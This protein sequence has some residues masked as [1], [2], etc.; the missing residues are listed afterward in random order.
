MQIINVLFDN[1]R[2]IF[3]LCQFMAI[4]V[5]KH[6]FWTDDGVTEFAKIFDFFVLMFVTEHLAGACLRNRNL[7]LLACGVGVA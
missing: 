4:M 7:W 2:H 1:I 3:E 6:A 5:R